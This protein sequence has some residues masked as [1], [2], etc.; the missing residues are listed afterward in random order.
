[1]LT[2]CE[3]CPLTT[4]E[5]LLTDV[6]RVTE[7][8]WSSGEHSSSTDPTKFPKRPPPLQSGRRHRHSF[9]VV[10]TPLQLFVSYARV[11]VLQSHQLSGKIY[12][13]RK[14]IRAHFQPLF[15]IT[16]TLCLG[17]LAQN[18]LTTED[19]LEEKHSSFFSLTQI[20]PN[21]SATAARP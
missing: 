16:S 7:A 20:R 1:M 19:W 14:F 17:F 9:V 15:I 10:A 18:F 6:T 5:T 3:E 12:Q 2:D 4:L 8:V 21:F 11:C 13:G